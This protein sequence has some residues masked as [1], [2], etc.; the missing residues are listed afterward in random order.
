MVTFLLKF[1]WFYNIISKEYILDNGDYMKLL[2]IFDSKN[3]LEDFSTFE[4]HACRGIIIKDKKVALVKSNLGY[5]KFPGGGIEKNESKKEALIREVLE[6]TGLQVIKE[7]IQ[8][9]GYTYEKRRSIYD[10]KGFNLDL[11]KIFIQYSYYYLC[12]CL[13]EITNPNLFDYEIDEEYPI[14]SI[15][16]Y[17]VENCISLEARVVSAG[18]TLHSRKQVGATI[19]CHV[20]PGAFGVLFVHK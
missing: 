1:I 9:F 16:S 5:Y 13:D 4:R 14:Y 20:G 6:E 19:G 3:Y 15:Y 18:Y 17:G 12:D 8:E 2:K 7:S 10:E 11:D